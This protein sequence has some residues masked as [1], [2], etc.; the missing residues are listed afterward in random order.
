MAVQPTDLC[1][2]DAAR[3]RTVTLKQGVRHGSILTPHLSLFYIDE[4]ASAV[5]ITLVSLFADDV[6]EWTQDTDMKKVTSKLQTGLDVPTS[7]S[8]SWKMNLSA[9]K[10]FLCYHK[11]ACSKMASSSIHQ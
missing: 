10:I 1:D 4:L 5:G 8:T 3:S 9:Q 7:W 11:H 2:Y 6:A